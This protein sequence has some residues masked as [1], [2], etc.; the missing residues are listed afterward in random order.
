MRHLHSSLI[1]ALMLPALG[2]LIN[3][4][5]HYIVE[6]FWHIKLRVTESDLRCLPYV[7]KL[8]N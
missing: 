6:T 4:F 3:M 7:G 8:V 2:Q 5:K 1:V